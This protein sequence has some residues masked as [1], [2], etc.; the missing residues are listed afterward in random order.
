M[1]CSCF[2]AGESSQLPSMPRVRGPQRPLESDG[3][4][5]EMGAL[6]GVRRSPSPTVGGPP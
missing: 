3:G 5:A 2:L 6:C 1:N 4:E